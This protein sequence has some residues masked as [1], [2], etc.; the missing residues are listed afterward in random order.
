MKIY[1]W[2]N[3]TLHI[4]VFALNGLQWYWLKK[5]RFQR[6]SARILDC[7]HIVSIYKQRQFMTV[8]EV[9]VI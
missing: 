6:F 4:Y 8:G 5:K 1:V 9:V 3:D 2:S 7:R